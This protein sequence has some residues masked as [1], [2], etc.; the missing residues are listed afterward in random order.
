VLFLG[1]R[2]GGALSAPLALVLIQRIG[3]RQSF[4]VFGAVGLVWAAA[5]FVWF[6]DS[7]AEHPAVNAE[8]AAWIAARFDRPPAAVSAGR[9]RRSEKTGENGT[10]LQEGDAAGTGAP[11]GLT[12]WRAIL[13][14]RNLYAICAMYF[15]FGY[16][17][18]FY[19]T[20]LPTYLI[21][22][23]GFSALQGGALAALPFLLA[24]LADI[25]GG[26]TTDRLAHTRGLWAARCGMGCASFLTCG[27]LLVASIVATDSFAKAVLLAFALASADFALGACWAVCLDVGADHAGVVT[28]FMNTSGN[29]G[30]FIGPLVVGYTVD[31]W[32]TWTLPFYISAAVYAFGALAWLTID[33]SRRFASR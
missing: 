20:W 28:G 16:G 7:P 25:A 23:L 5:W 15:A 29:L 33:P 13:G 11:D 26:W 6:R 30:G 18:Y 19:F 22:V 8:E 3:W 24:G 9:V 4:V 21:S 17:L 32:G 12:P 2:L 31:R 14:S 1:S 27:V 10:R